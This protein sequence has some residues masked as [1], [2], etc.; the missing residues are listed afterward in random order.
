MR[1]TE[2]E[3]PRESPHAKNRERLDVEPELPARLE[4][5]RTLRREKQNGVPR[6]RK[7][8]RQTQRLPLPAAHFKA[9]IEVKNAHY[10][11]LMLRALAYFR[12]V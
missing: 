7:P 5:G 1:V 4:T 2:I 10:S 11:G 8:F 6:L 9:G 3:L 12:K